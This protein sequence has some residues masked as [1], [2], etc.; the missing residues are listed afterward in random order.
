[1]SRRKESRRDLLV[2]VEGVATAT[3]CDLRRRSQSCR[4]AGW[5]RMEELAGKDSVSSRK[6]RRTCR[7]NF[8]SSGLRPARGGSDRRLEGLAG[9]EAPFVSEDGLSDTIRVSLTETP[10][11]EIDPCRRLANLGMRA[12][13]LQMGVNR[14]YFDFQ[15]RSGQLPLQKEGEEVDYRGVLHR[16]SSVLMSVSLDELKAPEFLY[17]SSCKTCKISPQMVD[18]SIGIITPLSEPLTPN[19]LVLVVL[20]IFF[21]KPHEELKILK[22]SDVVMILHDVPYTEENIGR[23]HAARRLFGNLSENTLD[24]PVI[25]HIQFPK[26]TRRTNAG[27]LL[28]DGLGDGILLDSPDQDFEILRNTSFNLLQGCRMRN[29]KTEYVSCPSCGRSLFDHQEI[30][31]EIRKKTSHLPGVSIAIMGCIVNGLGEMV[32][33]NFGY[34]VGAPGKIDLCT[35]VQRGIAMEYAT[36]ALIQQIKDHSRWVDPPVEE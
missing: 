29:T 21:P 33:A 6:R 20:T 24:F 13:E 17:K 3:H 35:M 36:D 2:A 34:V 5:S 8:T 23:V 18:I 26:Q 1:M 27:A 19:A 30:S 16:D 15:R 11:E 12:A 25:H 9:N 10:E 7:R 22:S 32:D 31:A 14:R 4:A 28:V